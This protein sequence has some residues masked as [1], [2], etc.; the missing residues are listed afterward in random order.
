MIGIIPKFAQFLK[1]SVDNLRSGIS[2][3]SLMFLNEFFQGDHCSHGDEKSE[4]VSCVIET[5]MPSVLIK[6]NYEKVFIS[7]EA[8]AVM[9]GSIKKCSHVELL[10]VL[11]HCPQ[12]KILAL[13]ENIY[14]F[15]G[16]FTQAANH[17]F[18]DLG[19]KSD[20]HK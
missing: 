7:K 1:D 19:N 15:V 10:N 3:N 14:G 5:V 9:T 20:S 4:A 16:L 11:L 13:H 6:T 18:F 8:K 12:H 17:E 2:K